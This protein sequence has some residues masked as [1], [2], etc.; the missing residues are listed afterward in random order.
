MVKTEY[1]NR[2]SF[3]FFICHQ[4]IHGCYKKYVLR[5]GGVLLCVTSLLLVY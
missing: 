2:C 5:G 4:K 1:F 3:A